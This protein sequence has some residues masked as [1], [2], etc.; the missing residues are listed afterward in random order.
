MR[1]VLL[2]T[3]ALFAAVVSAASRRPPHIQYQLRSGNIT[4]RAANLG[5]WLLT[6]YWMCYNSTLY[7]GVSPQDGIQGEYHVMKTLGQQQGNKQFEQ[8]WATWITEKD[9]Q[10]IAAAGLNTVR[11][12]TGYWIINDEDTTD[13][14]EITAT[15]PKGGLKYLDTL[16]NVWA[17]KYNVAVMVSLHAHKGSQNGMDHSA[18]VKMWKVEWSDDL[19]NVQ[20]SLRYATFIAH[21]YKN[22]PAFL[23]L[24]LMNE[25]TK[26]VDYPVLLQYYKDA[27]KAIREDGNDCI[28]VTSPWL[29]DQGPPTMADF[30]PCPTYYNVWHEYH[31]YY[32]WGWEHVPMESVFEQAANYGNSHILPWTGNPLFMGEWSLATADEAAMT[33]DLLKKFAQVQMKVLESAPAGWAFWAWRH[34]DENK[35]TS[36]WSMRQLLRKGIIT[37]PTTTPHKL[38]VNPKCPVIKYKI[39]STD[40]SSGSGSANGST[41]HV[42]LYSPEKVKAA[43]S[44]NMTTFAPSTSAA[45]APGSSVFGAA[46]LATVFMAFVSMV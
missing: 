45:P 42:S 14:S 26:G 29:Q 7:T 28:I 19:T 17:V 1:R 33:D 34:D 27:Y 32:K 22:S 41:P 16:I 11:V 10:E 24:N 25:P 12:S 31:A 37:I 8:H 15:Y 18:P 35:M 23:G 4:S 30:M 6:E 38:P 20:S 5:G 40:S 21:R 39:I 9:I 43:D 13:T 3:L 2:L 44:S 46:L 36:G